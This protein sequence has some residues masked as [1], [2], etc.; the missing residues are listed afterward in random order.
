MISAAGAQS[1][2]LYHEPFFSDLFFFSFSE[3]EKLPIDNNAPIDYD[4]SGY[5]QKT[6]EATN[7]TE[8]NLF[9]LEN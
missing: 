4:M 9:T 1:L 8:E 2:F 3:T 5:K 6:N 7:A